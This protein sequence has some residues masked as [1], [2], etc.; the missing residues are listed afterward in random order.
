MPQATYLTPNYITYP[1]IQLELEKGQVEIYT[2]PMLPASTPGIPLNKVLDYMA[3]GETDVVNGV[4]IDYVMLPLQA[5]DGTPFVD[6]GDSDNQVFEYS[7][8]AIITA[9]LDSALLRVFKYWYSFSNPGNNGKQ[10]IEQTEGR[11][12]IFRNLFNRFDQAGNIERKNMLQGMM[13]CSNARSRT[14][15]GVQPIAIPHGGDQAWAAFNSIPNLRWGF[16]R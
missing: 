12:N 3:K 4:L 10:I 1:M 14:S 5:T 15:T 9:M 8:N 13:P 11:V 7:Y 16:R 6:M 2:D